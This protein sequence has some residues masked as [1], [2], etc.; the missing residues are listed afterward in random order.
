MK[1]RG[2]SVPDPLRFSEYLLKSRGKS[3]GDSNRAI[4][5]WD[6]HAVITNLDF[7]EIS[8]THG[9]DEPLRPAG[10]LTNPLFIFG[11][12]CEFRS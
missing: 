7:L 11:F 1:I 2:K 3:A 12:L 5:R 9:R 4:R 10:T 6:G 8:A